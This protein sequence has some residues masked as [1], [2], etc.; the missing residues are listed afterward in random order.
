MTFI[1]GC[2]TVLFGNA[3]TRSA[4]GAAGEPL[5]REESILRTASRG[6][7][8]LLPYRMQQPVLADYVAVVDRPA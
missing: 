7:A 2:F 3:G 1:P 4:M 8:V 5:W 6:R